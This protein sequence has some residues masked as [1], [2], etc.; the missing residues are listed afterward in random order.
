MPRGQG[1][2]AGRGYRPV[3]AGH[4]GTHVSTGSWALPHSGL[5]MPEPYHYLG[6]LWE[7]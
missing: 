5:M 2:V 6:G 7:L 3:P 4:P 1:G